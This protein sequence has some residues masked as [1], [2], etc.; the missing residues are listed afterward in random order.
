MPV[1]IEIQGTLVQFPTS[2]EEPN[3]APPITQFAQL[4]ATALSGLIGPN[5]VSPQVYTMIA[6]TNTNVDLT[7]LQ[8]STALVRSALITYSVY[9]QTSNAN[10]SE[11]GEI[12]MVYNPNN[13]IGE[14]WEFSQQK[15]D[16][17]KITFNVLDTGQVQFSTTALG[18]TSH[19]GHISFYAK[20]LSQ[21]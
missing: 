17:G 14:K 4:V 8:F 12:Q 11:A 1:N 21:T 3:W 18:G 5:D 6:D 20:A 9:R 13:S 7:G 15:V 10:A 19:I 2:G 16:D